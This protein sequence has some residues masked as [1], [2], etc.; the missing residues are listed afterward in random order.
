MNS[1]MSI[2][3]IQSIASILEQVMCLS[4]PSSS[5]STKSP[6]SELA[7]FS[8]LHSSLG[9]VQW[10][11]SSRDGALKLS[12][13]LTVLDDE[14][15]EN[16]FIVRRISKLGH[17]AHDA[18][19]EFFAQFGAVRRIL[20]LPSRGRGDS[21][22]RPASMGFIVMEDALDCSRVC[23]REEYTV[24]HVGIQVQKF[25]RNAK[26]QVSDGVT[27]TSAYLPAAFAQPKSPERQRPH[28]AVQMSAAQLEMLAQAVIETL[29]I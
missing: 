1:D 22:T 2:P 15:E 19:L 21:R 29:E 16:I 14:R 12:D 4:T 3:S 11:S 26:I 20:L 24:G 10:Q 23:L 18:L 27:V 8:S 13:V 17:G 7:D 25:A 6:K 5:S 28:P 9:D